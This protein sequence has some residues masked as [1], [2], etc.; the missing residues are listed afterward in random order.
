MVA[1]NME[2]M[3]IKRQMVARFKCQCVGCFFLEARLK[4]DG[5]S[6]NLREMMR[7]ILVVTPTST[8]GG[9]YLADGQDRYP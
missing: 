4:D 2:E 7:D 5:P 3:T 6:T 1:G 9:E 8:G